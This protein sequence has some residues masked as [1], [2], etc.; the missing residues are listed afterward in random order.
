MLIKQN[1]YENL[2][3]ECKNIAVESEFTSRWVLIEGR[4]LLGN[5]ILKE[6][7]NFGDVKL[8]DIVSRVSEDINRSPRTVYRSIQFAKKFPDLNALPEGK[9]VS[10]KKIVTKYLPDTKRERKEAKKLCPQC[11]YELNKDKR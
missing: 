8:K 3:E 5:R 9:D 4:H 10:W 1:W 7:K 11:G 2:I 6:E